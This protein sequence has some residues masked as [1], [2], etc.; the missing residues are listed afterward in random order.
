MRPR[1]LQFL[2]QKLK[3]KKWQK[4]YREYIYITA[5]NLDWREKWA[6]GL[7]T[8]F[9][10]SEITKVIDWCLEFSSGINTLV[11][12]APEQKI[13]TMMF[14]TLRSTVRDYWI[15]MLNNLSNPGLE[16]ILQHGESGQRPDK[17]EWPEPRVVLKETGD[18]CP[19]IM[20]TLCCKMTHW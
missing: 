2:S 12:N 6:S 5:R 4:S 14:I 13:R 10:T 8:T 7:W 17:S 16:V 18:I 15:K 9:N 3:W 20:I 19:V 1:N 11:K